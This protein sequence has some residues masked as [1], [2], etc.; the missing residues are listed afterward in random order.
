MFSDDKRPKITFLMQESC[1]LAQRAII[2]ILLLYFCVFNISLAYAETSR[3]LVL[4]DNISA[5][6]LAPY[7]GLIEDPGREL[8]SRRALEAYDSG[9]VNYQLRNKTKLSFGLNGAPAWGVL[10]VRNE[11]DTEKFMFSLS[12]DLFQAQGS[13][14][15]IAVY[16]GGNGNNELSM[17]IDQA[18][19]QMNIPKDQ[20]ILLLFY[21]D[22]ANFIPLVLTPYVYSEE[23]FFVTGQYHKDG[24]IAVLFL[25]LGIGFSAFLAL[26]FKNSRFIPYFLAYCVFGIFLVSAKWP[27]IAPFYMG[28]QPLLLFFML[29]F[30][31]IGT[32]LQNRISLKDKNEIFSIGLPYGLIL[33]SF[34]VLSFLPESFGLMKVILGFVPTVLF[35]LSF[36]VLCLAFYQDGYKTAVWTGLFWFFSGFALILM[37]CNSLEIFINVEFL[38]LY[39]PYVIITASFM[40]LFLSMVFAHSESSTQQVF[41]MAMLPTS[42]KDLKEAEEEGEYNRLLTVVERERQMMAE[43]RQIDVRRRKD[44]QKAK[45]SA[46]AANRAKSA[47][48]AVVS[49][50]IRTP[51]TGIM[52]LVRLLMDTPLTEEQERYAKSI[53]ESGESMTLLLNDILDFEKIE[54]GKMT[55]ED[56]SFDVKQV[57]QSTAT[58]MA[59]HAQNKNIYLIVEINADAPLNI[60]GDASRL[61]QVL[62]NLV[63]NA[64]KFTAQGGVTIKIQKEPMPEGSKKS[65][66]NLTPISIRVED[67]GIG[68]AEDAIQRLFD[69]FSQADT[70]ISG[71]YGG[72]GLGLAICHRLIDLMGGDIIVESTEG[73]GSSFSIHLMVEIDEKA[74]QGDREFEVINYTNVDLLGNVNETDEKEAVAPV[75]Y[76]EK[77]VSLEPLENPDAKR[78][79]VVED[80]LVS[81]QVIESFLRKQ[82]HDVTSCSNAEDALLLCEDET[83]DIIFMD[84]ELPG[85]SGPEAIRKM[86]EAPQSPVQHAVLLT[87]H[88][89]SIEETGLP[90]E[91]LDGILGKPVMPEDLDDIITGLALGESKPQLQTHDEVEKSLSENKTAHINIS[92]EESEQQPEQVEDDQAE[93]TA[94]SYKA[95]LRD[96]KPAIL[97]ELD[98]IN[99]QEKQAKEERMDEIE[100]DEQAEDERVWDSEVFDQPMVSS[101]LET[102][103]EDKVLELMENVFEKTEEILLDLQTA[104]QANDLP[105]I[106]RRAHELKGMAGNFALLRIHNLSEAL[107][108][109]VKTKAGAGVGDLLIEIQKAHMEIKDLLS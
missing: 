44:M 28:F 1:F 78:I 102:L 80:N 6:A 14:E 36:V 59:G 56:V 27:L 9:A 41:D 42:I 15:T 2:S 26:I 90:V 61:R 4:K 85:M 29:T 22:P 21:I 88:R 38:P 12:R 48:L 11:S 93:S 46:D 89:V 108:E 76:V 3:Q 18:H 40:F 92:D 35:C 60:K 103:G 98:E 16:G 104:L 20:D 95:S 43:L 34:A 19:F 25:F 63:G 24:F 7:I 79:M 77:E 109:D 49:H 8:T 86:R 105:E 51:M 5:K 62:L 72:S 94:W 81:Q 100:G 67:T 87:G 106:S 58:L 47:F 39:T 74:D 97:R 30:V 52:G 69:P 32:F 71:Q 70:S 57:L 99:E 73:E 50:E 17:Q 54:T 84:W 101:L 53:M 55:L 33:I 31:A 75:P 83:F 96:E 45:E 10:S 82:G 23:N 65:Q 107:E 91:Y 13:I 66:K 68:I 37:F 64:I